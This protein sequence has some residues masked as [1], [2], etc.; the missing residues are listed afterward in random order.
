MV[1]AMRRWWHRGVGCDEVMMGTVMWYGVDG[2][3]A[4][5]DLW[6]GRCSVSRWWRQEMEGDELVK[7]V[8][9]VSRGVGMG[10]GAAVGGGYEGEAR[11]GAWSG[12]SDRSGGGESFGTQPENSPEKVASPEY[13][14]KSCGS[15]VVA[16]KVGRKTFRRRLMVA[17]GRKNCPAAAAYLNGGERI[18]YKC[19]CVC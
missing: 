19:E 3:G 5:V 10:G 8:V 16:R 12:R 9:V 2:D 14:P 17:G 1:A 4:T 13:S 6:W 18:L 11:G 15:W 7:M